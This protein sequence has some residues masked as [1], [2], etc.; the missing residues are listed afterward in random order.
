[1]KKT[2][3]SVFVLAAMA[4]FSSCNKHEEN[5]KKPDENLMCPDSNISKV[6][7]VEG[8][9]SIEI[10]KELILKVSY[11]A[12]NGCVGLCKFSELINGNTTQI[13]AL[14]SERKSEGLACIQ[15]ILTNTTDYK[16]IRST[17]G[18]YVLKFYQSD[19]T[20]ITHNVTVK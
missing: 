17:P 7:K 3:L 9:I 6:L 5:F 19:N 11:Q 13:T 8:P 20:F 4:I 10:N 12:H 16:F 15:V 18:N 1:M 2:I 14:T